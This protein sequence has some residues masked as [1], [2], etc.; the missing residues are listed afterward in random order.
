MPPL[1]AKANRLVIVD[2]DLD[3]V[4]FVRNAAEKIGFDVAVA[5]DRAGLRELIAEFEPTAFVLDIELPDTDAI[6][7]L[8]DLAGREV[9]SEIVLTGKT[10]RRVLATTQHLGESRGLKMAGKL[11]KPLDGRELTVTLSQI[12]EPQASITT[13]DLERAIEKREFIAY[14]QPKASLRSENLWVIDGVEALVRWQHPG[15]GLVMPDEFIPHAEEVG[16]IGDLTELMIE[17]SL[18]AMVEW[19]R[20]GLDLTCAINLTPS[21]A[22]DL[23]FPDRVV[24]VMRRFDIEPGRI[25]FELTELAT[26]QDPTNTMDILTRLRV[27]GFGLS[28]DDFGTGYSSIT[29]LYQMPFDEMKIDK[30][31]VMNVPH[32]RE[33]NTIVSSLIELGHNLGLKI[34]AEGVESR[35]ALDLLQLLQCDRCQGFYLSR[36]ISAQDIPQLISS[37]NGSHADLSDEEQ[38][39][40]AVI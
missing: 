7:I 10:D 23:D 17:N 1:H 12:Y 19:R 15:L 18:T 16:V 28:I 21:V 11:T 32:S 27:K 4:D 3:S 25:R 24:N 30:S 34:C 5:S 20:Q 39:V 40:M 38:Q 22:A 37:W 35:A 9:A 13:T 6:E 8:R 29:R 26:M 33:A 2:A 36:A 14:F 31:L